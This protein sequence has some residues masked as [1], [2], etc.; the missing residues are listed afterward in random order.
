MRE[1]RI[2]VLMTVYNRC[3][4][5][6]RCLS[7]LFLQA[8]LNQL[9]SLKVILVDD[10]SVDGTSNQIREEYPDVEI[11][12]GTG[13]LYWNGG[14]CLAYEFAKR[15]AP[16]FYL[17]LNDD[18]ILREDA[19]QHALETYRVR[20]LGPGEEGVIV[21]ATLDPSSNRT[22]YGCRR[23]NS[24]WHPFRFDVLDPGG[25]V[26]ACDTFDGNFVLINNAIVERI[27]FLDRAY[28]HRFGDTDYGL[29]ATSKGIK[30]WLCP[31]YVGV[32][33]RNDPSLDWDSARY[34]LRQ[35][36]S[37]LFDVK[38]MPIFESLHFCRKHG[39]TWWPVFWLLPIIRSIFFPNR[40][41]G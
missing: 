39:G 38:G 41:F 31:D 19:I 25:V 5:T 18:T 13:R 27:G 4:V 16:D 20:C 36:L 14:M 21:G 8:G 9:F 35:R 28:I 26:E 2:C 29:V 33:A 15:H 40:R 3:D 24:T 23:R 11:V 12:S 22:S 17:M 10:G 1:Y 30:I 34:T 32:C 7:R 6:L 37:K